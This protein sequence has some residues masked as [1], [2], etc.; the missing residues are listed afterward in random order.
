MET[1]SHKRYN[2]LLDEW[3]LVSPHR[4]QRPWQGQQEQLHGEAL[5]QFDPSCYLCPGVTRASGEQNPEYESTYIFTNDFSALLPADKAMEEFDTPLFKKKAEGGICKVVCFSPRH[6]LTIARMETGEIENIVAAW[7]KE[8]QHLEAKEDIRY[9][10]IF[11]NRGEAMGCSNPHPHGQI[12]ATQSVPVI[13]LREQ[14]NQTRYLLEQGGCLL[15]DYLRQELE[16]NERIVYAN[17]SFVV[18]VPYWA[19]WPFETMILP[20]RHMD[21]ISALTDEET[22]DLAMCMKQ[23]AVRYD[24]LFQTAFPYSMGLHQ[25]PTDKEAHPEWHFHL[26]FFPPLLRS[27]TIKKFMVG[28]EMLGMAQRDLTAEEAA[29]RLREQS[30]IHFTEKRG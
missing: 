6:D 28:F 5:P 23:I 8:Y 4:R 19:V 1:S 16:L 10:Q 26:H 29:V 17:D 12:W 2:P 3:I 27:A 22:A 7:Q 25:R 18:L 30:E 20:Q 15:C 9:V 24:N 11:E 14:E 13:P 21:S